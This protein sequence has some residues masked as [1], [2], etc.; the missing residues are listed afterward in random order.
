MPN[1]GPYTGNPGMKQIPSDPTNV[2]EIIE[3]FSETTYLKSYPR[4]LIC[5]IFKIKENIIV[6]LRG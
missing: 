4:G 2:S 6:V 5:I 3:L 1:L